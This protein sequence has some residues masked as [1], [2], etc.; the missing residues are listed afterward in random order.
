MSI[1]T[2]Q[3]VCLHQEWHQY[4]TEF[5][6]VDALSRMW[7]QQQTCTASPTFCPIEPE[8]PRIK[9]EVSVGIFEL[10]RWHTWSWS[11]SSGDAWATSGSRRQTGQELEGIETI[12]KYHFWAL[13]RSA[14]TYSISSVAIVQLLNPHKERALSCSPASQWQM[15]F[16][17]R[18]QEWFHR[19]NDQPFRPALLWHKSTL[20][21]ISLNFDKRGRFITEVTCLEHL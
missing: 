21:P 17:C 8:G 5:R 1:H 18:I 10:N 20:C 16:Y 13:M 6:A 2:A 14:A 15:F 12:S 9:L 11:H 7:C 19:G 3:T 4:M